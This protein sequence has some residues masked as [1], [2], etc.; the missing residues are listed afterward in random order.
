MPEACVILAAGVINGKTGN[1]IRG[2][3]QYLR[4]TRRRHA[5]SAL[6]K[7]RDP[8]ARRRSDL[9]RKS[10]VFLDTARGSWVHAWAGPLRLRVG[11]S[12]VQTVCWR[13][14]LES[15]V[16]KAQDAN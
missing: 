5:S 8:E 3:A 16:R 15:A 14:M 11:I 6:E 1:D 10:K 12:E 9:T 2:A 4:R 13:G 7:A